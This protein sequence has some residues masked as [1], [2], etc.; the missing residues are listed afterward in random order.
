MNFPT[1]THI[2]KFLPND[3]HCDELKKSDIIIIQLYI[4]IK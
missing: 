2:F 1:I 4:K 3:S